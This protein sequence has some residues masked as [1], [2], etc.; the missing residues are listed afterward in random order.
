MTML[1]NDFSDLEPYA[2]DWCL[3][4][5]AERQAQRL[6]STMP[7]IQAFY[8][9]VTARADAAM[10]YLDQYTLEDLPED[11]VNLMLLIF[12]WCTV[13]FAVE[14]WSQ[15]RIPDSGASE[16]DLISGPAYA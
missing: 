15:P 3:P 7:Q 9:A 12:S 5:E 8:D 16:L 13:S 14:C 1:P 10:T 2:A 11:A 6:A 4:T